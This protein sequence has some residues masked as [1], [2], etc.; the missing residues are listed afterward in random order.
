M[1]NELKKVIELGSVNMYMFHGGTNFGFMNGC[2]AR[3]TH[4]L[5]QITSYDYGA[6]LN[7]Q[8]NPT[9]GYYKIKKMLKEKYP[10]I[11]QQDPWVKESF[12]L[13]KIRLQ[14]KVSLFEVLDEIGSKTTTKYPP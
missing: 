1:V 13:S 8:G 2:S 4:D 9:E 11:S 3:G 6:P 12:R 14:D 5:P 10:N 7:E